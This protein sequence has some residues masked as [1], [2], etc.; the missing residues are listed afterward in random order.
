[1]A[2]PTR[3]CVKCE[4]E[5][6]LR[7]NHAGYANRCPQCNSPEEADGPKAASSAFEDSRE[8]NAARR[9]AIKDMLYPGK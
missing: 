6:E 5:F 7:P 1:M 3:I 9:A 8:A 2:F 4:E